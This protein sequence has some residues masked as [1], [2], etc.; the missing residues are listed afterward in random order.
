MFQLRLTA[1]G[2]LI[3]AV[4][5]STAN[6]RLW[7]D[8][9]GGYTVEADLIAFDDEQVVLAR[10]DHHLVLVPLEKL[11]GDDRDYLESKEATESTRRLADAMQTWTMQG[12]L[13]IVG[14]I[15]NYGRKEITLQRRRGKIYVNDRRFENLPEV[16]QR[17]V[18][19]IVAHFE[20]LAGD[21]RRALEAWLVRQKGQPR[22]FSC[23][24]VVLELENGDEYGVPFFFF[25]QRDLKVLR[26][27]WDEWL[28]DQD[29]YDQQQDDAFRL[30][31][32]AAAYHRDRQV[33][34]QIAIT[35]LNL[36]AVQGGITSVWEVTLYPQSA[37]VGPPMSVVTYGR[38]SRDATNAALAQYPGY[39]AGPVRKVSGRY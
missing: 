30:Q 20:H 26:P 25:S 18:P 38:N 37:G 35:Q 9:T 22:T 28:A 13:K 6:A 5:P 3:L 17:M 11:S 14:R 2:W 27:G 39:T 34:Q 7:T 31:S 19:K 15:V 23:E 36:Q 16:Y 10:D 32:L 33:E 24:G 12:G 8:S 29:D 4:V 21:N 1:F